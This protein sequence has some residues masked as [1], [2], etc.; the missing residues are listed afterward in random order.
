MP[1]TRERES[2]DIESNGDSAFINAGGRSIVEVAI[3]GDNPADYRV[4]GREDRDADWVVGVMSDP[5]YSGQ[6]DY[7]DTL[8]T[9]WDGIRI[10]CVNGTGTASDNAEII[11][12]AAGR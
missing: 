9:G 5:Q 1:S 8:Q 11:L 12:C 10:Y 4:D 3:R 6:S 7:D 2:I